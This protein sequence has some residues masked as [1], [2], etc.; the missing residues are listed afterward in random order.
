M[1]VYMSK[2]ILD[3]YPAVKRLAEE[4][5]LLKHFEKLPEKVLDEINRRLIKLK[6]DRVM[7]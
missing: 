5:N 4:E 6:L 1:E 2:S 3:K 7:E